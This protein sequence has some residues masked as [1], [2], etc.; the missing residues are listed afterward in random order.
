[1]QTEFLKDRLEAGELLSDK[2]KK[3]QDTDTLILAIPRGGVPVGY[4]IA[5]NL[6]LPLDIILSKKIGHP[7]N[8]EFAIGAVSEDSFIIDEHSGVSSSYIEN[9]VQRL[10]TVLTEKYKLYK[11]SREPV[12][13]EGKDI[14]L[15]DDG[16]ATG[17]T[18]LVTIAM[19]R[20]KNVRKIIVAIAVLPTSAIEKFI[21]T[22]DELVYLIASPNFTSVGAFYKVFNQ[23]SDNE[24][25]T[26]LHN[27]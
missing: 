27:S 11:P 21:T 14:I 23:V 26:M 20:K 2:L 24:V 13:L 7:N 8:K 25:I 10:R 5:K 15:V 16:I 3:Y 18:L 9:E 17:N 6:K 4:I 1:M 22:A 12:A 19:L